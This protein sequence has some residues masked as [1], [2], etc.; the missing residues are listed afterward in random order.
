MATSNSGMWRSE[1]RNFD[2]P[3][4]GPLRGK[5]LV[6]AFVALA[7]AR[8]TCFLRGPLGCGVQRGACGEKW[9]W[10]AEDLAKV[11]RPPTVVV[12]AEHGTPQP[13]REPQCNQ[14]Q[15]YRRDQRR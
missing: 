14:L 15:R 3:Q 9:V 5:R 4:R 11:D 7:T 6:V 2:S 8:M 12:E 13:L 10:S 1:R